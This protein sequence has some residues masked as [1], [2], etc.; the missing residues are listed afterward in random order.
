MEENDFS[1]IGFSLNYLSQA[2]CT[3]AMAGFLRT[4]HSR[5]KIILGG[6]LVTSWL[7]RPQSPNHFR[8]IIDQLVAGPGEEALL[9]L[10]G[11]QG[12]TTDPATPEYETLPL[13]NY[14]APGRII[15]YRTASG[16]YWNRCTFCSM[17]KDLQFEKR[18]VEEV[19]Q[20][21][22]TLREFSR[23]GVPT[24]FIGDSNSLVLETKALVEILQH[25][26][27]VFPS[28]Q[29]VTSYARARTLSKK[30]ME[31]LKAIRQA[32]L[33]RLHIGLET[34]DPEL[35]EEIKKGATPEQMVEGALR[36]KEAGFE[37]SLYVLAGI[38]GEEKWKQHAEGTAKVLNQISPHFIRIR[39]Y[40]PTPFSPL[41]DK[42]QDGSFELA[43]AE[44]ILM[45]Q[46][47]LIELLQ[48]TSE[49]LS[50]HISNY[51]PVYGQLP[52]DQA[53]MLQTI[54][55]ALTV[56]RKDEGYRRSLES[57]RYLTAL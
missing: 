9:S 15:P 20:D 51:V 6:G 27:K 8:G 5:A 21:I 12:A 53:A 50:D 36:A 23:G 46:R 26:Y 33:T 42:V 29:R 52:K 1:A 11:I 30:P 34:G 18:P 25:L 13:D 57:K 43:S 47:R 37:V 28:V 3:F 41:W 4:R 49:Y 54:D 35:L 24:V 55:Q 32:G 22:D 14:V 31:E 56:L 40:V 19:L 39:T 48:V 7:R 44:A 16:C 38:W 45:E 17:Y 10:A 2:L